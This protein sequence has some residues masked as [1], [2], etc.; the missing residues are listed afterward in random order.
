M[1]SYRVLRTLTFLEL[2]ASFGAKWEVVWDYSGGGQVEAFPQ[3]GRS[4]SKSEPG[5]ARPQASRQGMGQLGYFWQVFLTCCR[6]PGALLLPLHFW[7]LLPGLLFGSG[8]WC[9]KGLGCEPWGFSRVTSASWP[10]LPSVGSGN[11]MAGLSLAGLRAAA[12]ISE[13]SLGAR[14]G[15]QTP[16]ILGTGA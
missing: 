10:P 7:A 9:T 16:L 2:R 13:G 14:L 3:V 6:S 11:R 5:L 15:G 8:S 4:L 12:C 1:W